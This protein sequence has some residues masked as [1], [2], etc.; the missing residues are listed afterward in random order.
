M[1][2]YTY[3]QALVGKEELKKINR[4]K[5]TILPLSNKVQKSPGTVP[6]LRVGSTLTLARSSLGS[7]LG[8]S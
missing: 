5:R 4:F 8:W 3:L 7:R 1:F 2:S 6:V